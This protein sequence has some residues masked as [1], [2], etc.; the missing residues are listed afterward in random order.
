MGK[1]V[2]PRWVYFCSLLDAT[3]LSQVIAPADL[4]LTPSPDGSII[5]TGANP[6]QGPPPAAALLVALR[7]A[8][9]A[10]SGHPDRKKRPAKAPP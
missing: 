2:G 3:N 4:A 10:F 5:S 9:A 8:Y 1:S 6:P 7:A